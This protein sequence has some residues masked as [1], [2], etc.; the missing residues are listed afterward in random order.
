MFDYTVE[1]SKS[2]RRSR[3]IIGRKFEG[4][5]IWCSVAIRRKRNVGE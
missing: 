5:T 2:V 1:T 3:Q 4:K